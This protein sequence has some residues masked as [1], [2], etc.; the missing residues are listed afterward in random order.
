MTL[1]KLLLKLSRNKNISVECFCAD[2]KCTITLKEWYTFNVLS[3][4]EIN[5][6][7]KI[8]PAP[9]SNYL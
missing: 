3:K 4:I 6:N 2:E 8:D 5:L 9:F 7:E 1:Q